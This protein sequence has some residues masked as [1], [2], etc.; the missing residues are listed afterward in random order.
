MAKKKVLMLI[1]IIA[2]IGLVGGA[3]YFFNT[4]TQQQRT[5]GTRADTFV[6]GTP[7]GPGIDACGHI[8]VTVEELTAC[9]LLAKSLN[10]DNTPKTP[11]TA[12][13]D[14]SEY[15]TRYYL[16]NISSQK[17]TVTYTRMAF[18]CEE[19][20][21]TAKPDGNPHCIG[22]PDIKDVTI[23]LEPGQ[24]EAIDIFVKNN[25][26]NKCGS[27]QTDMNYGSFQ[28]DLNIKSVDGKEE[29]ALPSKE[30]QASGSVAAAGICQ[31]G[32]SAASC[33]ANTPTPAT[34]PPSMTLQGPDNACYEEN[35]IIT[36][37]G[38]PGAAPAPLSYEVYVVKKNHSQFSADECPGELLGQYC[39][40]GKSEQ[41]TFNVNTEGLIVGDYEVFAQVTDANKKIL[42]S[43]DPIKP[44]ETKCARVCN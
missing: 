43:N 9:S 2:A 5:T 16:K 7:V 41:T 23:T 31:T 13:V 10:P 37:S 30:L 33:P 27:F 40:L 8:Q 39:L 36:A 11:V 19:P 34:L 35:S 12:S 3:I 38:N 18:F 21:G 32:K 17:R 26:A 28:T 4:V 25:S 14:I 15:K 24:V 44:F 22:N 6:R 42:C 29:C 1:L 20:F